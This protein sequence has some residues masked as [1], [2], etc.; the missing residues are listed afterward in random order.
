MSCIDFEKFV[1]DIIDGYRCTARELESVA[2]LPLGQLV[3]GAHRVTQSCSSR[4]FNF[5]AIVN[6]KSG[7]CSENCRWCAQS[8]H[9]EGKC[10][11][12]PL[13]GKQ[14][15]IENALK[16]KA[17]GCTRF[18]LVTSG[19]KLAAREVRE[20]AEIVRALRE[21]T[22]ME[23]CISAGLLTKSEFELLHQ[24][25]V[26]RC[27]CNLETAPTFFSKVCDSHTIEDK[28]KS[29]KAACEAGLEI[30]SGGIIGMGEGLKERIE[31]A[32]T[33]RDLGVPSIP[34]NVLEP[35]AGTPLGTQPYLSED[36][37][38]RTIALF[39]FANP[40]AYLRF[41]GGRRRL[42]EQATRMALRAG[43]NS[44]IAGDMLTTKG[45]GIDDDKRLVKAAGY[46][47]ENENSLDFDHEHLWHPYAGTLS[48][49]AVHKVI[50]TEGTRITLDDGTQL[51]DGT[52][53]WWCAA[54]GHR[55]PKLVDAIKRQ[56]DTLPHVMF[57]GF[58]HDPAIEL[59]RKLLKMV[60]AGLQKIFYADSGSV[61]IEAAMKMAIQ[62]QC[63]VGQ[64]QRTNFVTIK[65]G[66][67][68]DTW[69]AM[70]V[71]D[72]VA[73]MHSLFGSALT[74]RY[75]IESPSSTFDG[76]FNEDDMQELQSLL[77]THDDIAALILEPVF[78]GASAMRFYHPRFLK[79]AKTLCERH[80]VLF[81]ADEIATGFGRTGKDFACQ[82]ANI[83]PDIM[84]LG[85]AL[86]GG[87]MTL[88]CVL[89]TN[90]IADS[91]SAAAPHAFMHGPTFMANPLACAA[92]N[93]ALQLYREHD[94][95]G[96]AKRIEHGLKEGLFSLR[97]HPGIRDVRVLGAIGVVELDQPVQSRW[98]QEEFIRQGVW[99]RPIGNLCY[100]MPPLVTTDQELKT[101]T[102]AVCR[103][104][105]K[106]IERQ[107][108]RQC[109]G[110][111]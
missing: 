8:S 16:A 70:S 43:I 100:L 86:T 34:I 107:N 26:T 97:A 73:G 41:A 42:S 108:S 39:R 2:K 74:A 80:G 12:Y 44:A 32:L 45:T 101:L 104:L 69:N 82:W 28:I 40:A 106:Q 23:I 79:E 48:A 24:A 55:H 53:A 61:A 90:K 65:K 67:H 5:C 59:G 36:E 21:V 84:T 35:I 33:L 17:S 102:M 71:C 109:N 60:P 83:T 105:Q 37:I 95:L 9:Y 6:A 87:M 64:A 62:Y 22:S 68:G 77:Q 89:T 85:K 49:P 72:P 3:D 63:A 110:N 99:V 96:E 11:V 57:A 58:T 29:L 14:A 93:A 91:I 30:C 88:S 78:Q 27:H 38:I 92:A 75:F 47:L 25:G 56:L 4:T 51:I 19:R 111:D 13:L 18:S 54:F 46:R 1:T 15:I 7:R 94:W 10:S 103:V 98:I 52:S 81:I 76:H 31:L 66:Y 20:C 50:A